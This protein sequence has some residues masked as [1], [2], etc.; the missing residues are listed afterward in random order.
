[1]SRHLALTPELYEH[2]CSLRFDQ[3]KALLKGKELYIPRPSVR[4]RVAEFKRL[5]DGHNGLSLCVRLNL[6][7][8]QYKRALRELKA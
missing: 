2:L 7:Q 4:V 8:R 5:Y 3:A 6:S 1:M